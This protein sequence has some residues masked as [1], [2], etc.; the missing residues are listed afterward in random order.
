MTHFSLL[1]TAEMGLA[2]AFHRP[3]II[4]GNNWVRL[5]DILTMSES[6]NTHTIRKFNLPFVPFVELNEF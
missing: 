6:K 4:T 2:L 1:S 3:W 5:R